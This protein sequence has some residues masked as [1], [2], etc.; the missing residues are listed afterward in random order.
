MTSISL[1]HV[2]S[3]TVPVKEPFNFRYTLWKPSHF[4]TGL[5]Q[6]SHDRSW[7]TFRIG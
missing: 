6:H 1:E 4:A 7:R 2:D 3:L 5:E